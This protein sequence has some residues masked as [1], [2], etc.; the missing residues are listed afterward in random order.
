M[1]SGPKI[2]N[3]ITKWQIGPN[4]PTI[5]QWVPSVA[6]KTGLLLVPV[7]LFGGSCSKEYQQVRFARQVVI[8]QEYYRYRPS[9]KAGEKAGDHEEI[10]R[11]IQA[12]TER[13]FPYP[14][15]DKKG[16]LKALDREVRYLERG[17][18]DSRR[19]ENN[20]RAVDLA[21]KGDWSAATRLW[22]SLLDNAQSPG[23][24]KGEGDP[25]ARKGWPGL[26]NNLA[27]ARALQK[28]TDESLALLARALRYDP[29]NRIYRYHY[30]AT[31]HFASDP[32]ISWKQKPGKP[33]NLLRSGV[34][35]IPRS[36]YVYPTKIYKQN[37][38][39]RLDEKGGDQK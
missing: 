38:A 20:N 2:Y 14:P 26:Y 39:A 5:P 37:R 3:W 30:A 6:R 19:S 7:L 13:L 8:G 21:L 25:Q 15:D 36:A 28:K 22:E 33:R 31:L 4:F 23:K 32:E 29:D 35:V 10:L 16:Q 18:P 34:P 17:G 24:Q 27:L 12:Q 11:Q 1:K 9:T